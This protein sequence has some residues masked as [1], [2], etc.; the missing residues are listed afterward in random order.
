VAAKYGI[1]HVTTDLAD[2]L[3]LPEVDAVI[4]CTPTQMHAAQASPA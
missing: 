4:L 1:G 2:S 3:A